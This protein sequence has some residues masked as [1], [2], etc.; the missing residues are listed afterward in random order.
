MKKILF[1]LLCLSVMFSYSQTSKDL[2]FYGPVFEIEDADIDVD[3]N[4]DFKIDFDVASISTSKTE[5][6]RKFVTVARHLQ[7]HRAPELEKNVV[8]AVLVVHGS[9]IFDLFTHQE[10]A[11][12]HQKE[13]LKNPNYDLLSVLDEEG[14]DIVLCGQSAKSR[15]ITRDMMHPKV[16]LALSAMSMHVKLQ[17]ENYTLIKL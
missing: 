1:T 5:A 15:N 2:K 17:K 13:G 12:Y 9:A 4:Q 3:L 11:A 14:V 16:K 7:L 8:K 6:N 10:F